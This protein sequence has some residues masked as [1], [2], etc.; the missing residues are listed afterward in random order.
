MTIAI[1]D[2]YVLL[3]VLRLHPEGYGISIREEISK[4]TG[5]RPSAGAT[6]A[7]LVRLEEEGLLKARLGAAT[8]KRGGRGK[9]YFALTPKGRGSLR[10]ALRGFDALR[11]GL[12]V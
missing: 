10:T 4:R 9:R 5:H 3:A 7:A 11:T 2:Q 6:Y 8:A 12:G 1:F